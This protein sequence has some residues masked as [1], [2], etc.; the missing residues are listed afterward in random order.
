MIDIKTEDTLDEII[1]VAKDRVSSLF[2]LNEE[3]L[4]IL[5]SYC[6]AFNKVLLEFD[7]D[8]Y[9]I[10]VNEDTLE[11]EMSMTCVGIV[12]ESKRHLFLELLDRS[13]YAELISEDGKS[14]TV[15]LVFPSLWENAF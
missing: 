3:K 7:A 9:E 14:V 12:I 11:I 8:S 4:E 2:R 15:K 5:K 13:V 10:S 6:R 1:E